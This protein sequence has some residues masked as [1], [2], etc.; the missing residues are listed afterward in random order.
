[1]SRVNSVLSASLLEL[2]PF[3][4]EDLLLFESKLEPV[5]TFKGSFLLKEGEV[6]N[7]LYFLNRGSLKHYTLDDDNQ[8]T[9]TNLYTPG[10]WLTEFQSFTSQQPSGYFLQA[11]EDSELSA[12]NIFSLHTLILERP[13]FFCLGKLFD[14]TRYPNFT[15]QKSPQDK[16]TWLLKERPELILKFPLKCLASYLGITPETLSRVRAK[17]MV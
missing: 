3:S 13:V 16:Y 12:L 1:M 2:G 9:I 7:A 8:E 14:K 10:N 5:I 11:F 6:C 15:D 4:A 17:T